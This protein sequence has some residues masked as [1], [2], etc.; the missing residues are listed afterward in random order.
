MS[1]SNSSSVTTNTG[2]QRITKVKM[3]NPD[4]IGNLSNEIKIMILSKLSID[5]AVRCSVL[6]KR[7]EGLWKEISH[8]ELNVKTMVKPFTQLLQSRKA[9]TFPDFGAIAPPMVKSVS[10][11]NSLVIMMILATHSGAMSSCRIKHFEKSLAFGDVECWVHILVESK[12]GLKDLSLESM[13]HCEELTDKIVS[14]EHTFL[15]SFLHG[16]FECLSSLE[17]INYTLNSCLPFEECNKLKKLTM[18]RIYLDDGTLSGILKN[19]VVLENFNL[20]ESTGFERLIIVKSTLRVLQLQALCVDEIQLCCNNLEVLLLESVICAVKNVSISSPYLKTF[21][22]YSNSMYA[23]M[24]SVENGK[25]IMKTHEVLA[26]CSGLVVFRN[27]NQSSNSSKYGDYSHPI[28]K[29]WQRR[30][31]CYCIGQK[32]KCVYIR[33]F[34][35]KEQEVEFGKYLITKA[36]MMKRITLIC[37]SDSKEAAEKLLSLPMASG[38]LSINLILNGNNPMEEF[39]EHQ[40]RLNL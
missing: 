21:H 32:L 3:E 14:D 31:L 24:L 22:S 36:T 39:V 11:C 33:G 37:S 19:C 18:K 15:P 30:E 27:K 7:W 20:L 25:S 10:R 40:N 23:K 38:N 16:V 17:L 5:E 35:G 34:R 29:L 2:G 12:K 4:L 28:S 26:H 1:F 13:P 6:S 8:M 9:R